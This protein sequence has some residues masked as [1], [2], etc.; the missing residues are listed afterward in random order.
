MKYLVDT[1]IIISHLKG[2]KIIP[3]EKIKQGLGISAITYGELLV[4]VYRSEKVE[5]N[6][7]ILESFIGEMK[8]EI[9]DVD[10][11]IINGYA[12]IK[13]ELEKKG[14][15]LDDFDMLI[16]VTAKQTSLILLTGNKKHFSK[17]SG[18]KLG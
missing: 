12:K 11:E 14:R 1:D 3:V 4:G 15:M 7:K 17:I 10:R 8:I 13:A 9:L 5:K 18:L 2:K 6:R 16:G